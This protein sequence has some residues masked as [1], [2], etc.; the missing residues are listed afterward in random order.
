MRANSRAREA[1]IIS[2]TDI[3]M[4]MIMDE[5]GHIQTLLFFSLVS[6]SAQIASI[7]Y[8]LYLSSFIVKSEH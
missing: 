3:M 7:H 8:T 6:A 4:M 2:H 5:R 1:T